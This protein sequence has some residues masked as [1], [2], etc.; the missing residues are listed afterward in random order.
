MTYLL[1][2]SPAFAVIAAIAT[3]RTGS[4]GAALIGLAVACAVALAVP[5]QAF[6]LLEAGTALARGAWIGWIVVPYI[7]G[8]LFFWQI[9]LGSAR[10]ATPEETPVDARARRRM[11]FAACFLIGPF[12][13]SATGFGVGIVGT[14]ALVRRLGVAPIPLLVFGLLSQTMILWGG[15]GSGAIVS[16]AFARMDPTELAVN[17]SLFMVAFNLL[18]LPC[19]WR[20]ADAS[21]VGSGWGERVS[22]ALWLGAAQ[23]SVIAATAGL[24]PEAAMLASYGPIIVLRYLIDERPDRERLLRAAR[25]VAPFAAL[26]GC[27]VLTRLVPPLKE[28][29]E[30][31]GRIQPF[32]GVP[33]WSPL[34]HAGSW[35][36]L[37]GLV[38]GWL[39]GRGRDFPREVGAAWRTGRL[40]VLTIIAFAM[41][42]ELLSGSGIADGLARGMFEALGRWSLLLT[43]M[44]SAVFGA[45]A[46]S[47]NAANG[48]FMASQL[49]LA[50]EAGLSVAAVA[51]L[52]QAAA[53]SLNIVSPVRMSIVCSLAGTP[54]RER[55]A[56]RAMFPFAATAII[57]LLVGAALIVTRV[58]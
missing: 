42:A 22:E 10:G 11:L 54:G 29:L 57:V 48:L 39:R 27:M 20:V 38:T 9:A 4:L 44:L 51:S 6:H 49:S 14:M 18:W 2:A 30:A 1:W 21:G 55:E 5:P 46:N 26:I 58:I 36:V 53:L 13:E 19:Y 28:F 17:S 34:F 3:G 41:M 40:A 52:Q 15:M 31:T 56:Y 35:L 45:L 24:G 16:A 7:L 37:A 8:G 25:R 43:P 50:A 47:G 33:A 23:V 12:A 32:D